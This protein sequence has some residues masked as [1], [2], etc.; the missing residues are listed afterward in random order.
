MYATHITIWSAQG[1]TPITQRKGG[2]CDELAS[3]TMLCDTPEKAKAA[4]LEIK[5]TTKHAYS[6]HYSMP[7]YPNQ[8]TKAGYCHFG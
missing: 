8:N 3:V 7:D 2:Y 4:A 6:C 5:K 1:D